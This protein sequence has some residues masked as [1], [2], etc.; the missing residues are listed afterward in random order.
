MILRL[1]RAGDRTEKIL[2]RSG[3]GEH[4]VALELAKADDSVGIVQVGR[5]GNVLCHARVRQVGLPLGKV[6]VEHA[7]RL[8]DGR[9]AAGTVDGVQMPRCVG[10]AWAVAHDDGRAAPDELLRQDPQQ[11]R[12]G[13]CGPLRLHGRDEVRLDGDAHAGLYPRKAAER[14]KHLPQGCT[15]GLRLIVGT[16][17]NGRVGH[18]AHTARSSSSRRTARQAA[19][20]F[21]PRVPPHSSRT[22]RVPA[23][24]AHATKISPTRGFFS[25]T[26]GPAFPVTDRA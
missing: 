11:H 20:R 21:S 22:H 23:A 8:L 17:G 12:M 25:S 13:R 3:K 19:S 5:V 7:A 4:A 16:R 26:P 9:K 18:A 6:P 1:D 2:R 15:A 14:R 24:S 10:A